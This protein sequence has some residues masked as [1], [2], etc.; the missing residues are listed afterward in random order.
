MKM[1]AHCSLYQC[2]DISFSGVAIQAGVPITS[3]TTTTVTPETQMTHDTQTE[4]TTGGLTVLGTY[5]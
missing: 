3:F 4:D 1:H 2:E 5:C